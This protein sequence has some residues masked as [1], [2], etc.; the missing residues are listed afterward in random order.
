MSARALGFDLSFPPHSQDTD[1]QKRMEKKAS[2]FTSKMGPRNISCMHA[3]CVKCL[4][5]RASNAPDVDNAG[6]V[7]KI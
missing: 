1:G 7:L 6:T 3:V 2:L 4:S 5:A